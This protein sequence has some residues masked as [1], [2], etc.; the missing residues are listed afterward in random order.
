M[1]YSLFVVTE[2]LLQ[3]NEDFP[4]SGERQ[5]FINTKMRNVFRSTDLKEL[6]HIGVIDYLQ[7]WNI[8]KKLEM[9]FKSVMK[10]AD[11]N[12]LSSVN[13]VKY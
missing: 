4:E 8:G 9:V 2:K 3:N 7:E 6:Y 1:D 12:K 13:P 5:K 11:S 10:G